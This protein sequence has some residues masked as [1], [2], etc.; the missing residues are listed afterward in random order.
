MI[1]TE[2][3]IA[4]EKKNGKKIYE[5]TKLYLKSDVDF[6]FKDVRDVSFPALEGKFGER[7]QEFEE[8]KKIN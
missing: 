7:I 2:D 3:Q 6:V 4:E 8:L 1:K 5:T